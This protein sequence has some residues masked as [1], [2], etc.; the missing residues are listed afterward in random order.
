[1]RL[2]PSDASFFLREALRSI[3]INWSTNAVSVACI[4]L[5]LLSLSF[6]AAGW[7]NME[8]LLEAA[9]QEAEI[10]I[11]LGDETH[12]GEAEALSGLLADRAG[13]TSVSIVS[14]EETLSRVQ[15]LLGPQ[16]DI[17]EVLEDYNPFTLSLEVGVLPEKAGDVARFARE[18]PGVDLVRDNE[19]ILAPLARLTSVARW[20]GLVAAL[21]VGLVSLALV[22]HIIRLGISARSSEMETL[23]LL[24]ASE[25]F[26]ALPF[27]LEGAL[28]G[29]LGA[30]VSLMVLWAG[31]P[32]LY[33]L[34]QTALPFLPLLPW[35]EI[36]ATLLPAVLGL[37]LAAGTLGAL[38]SLGASR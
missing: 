27:L 37:G 25:G 5:A 15:S 19:E 14:P 2:S 11:Y 36:L 18:L 33:T 12:A 34:L 31:G 8:Y 7:L 16:L 10:V 28:L 21:T 38:V 30:G 9:R 6:L 4:V 3:R 29:G 13:V 35:K 26:L 32:S 22:S 1:M 24:G 23:R 17:L 20:V